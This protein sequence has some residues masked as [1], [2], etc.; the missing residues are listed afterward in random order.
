MGL[1]S[2]KRKENKMVFN[3][4]N[5]QNDITNKEEEQYVHTK[6]QKLQ[7]VENC[8]D[9]MIIGQR[10]L[11]ETKVE[12]NQVNHYLTDMHTIINLDNP[13]RDNLMHE[14]K[15]IINLK[16]DK[17]S[18]KNSANKMSEKKYE[19]ISNHEREM[20]QI[21]K[22]LKESEDD[23]QAIKVN[24]HNIEGEKSALKYERKICINRLNFYRKLL[25]I[26]LITTALILCAFTYGH[27]QGEYDYTIGYY[28]VIVTSMAS[29]AGIL[30]GNQIT[31]K[32]L[33]ISELKLNKAIGLLNRYKLRYVNTK[34][35]LD[36]LYVVYGVNNSYELSNLWRV[37]LTSKKEREAYFKMSDNLYKATENYMNIIN[38]LNLYDSSVWNYQVHAIIDLKEMDIIKNTLESR[39]ENLCKIIDY[40][41]DLVNRS[42]D[43]IKKLIED[44]NSITDDVLLIVER[45]EEEIQ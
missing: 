2:R 6:E 38:S 19:Y 36:Y 26:V 17:T 12:Y 13:I 43:R 39:R 24:L 44:D 23:C 32:N 20:P 42:K 33:K 9:Q 25:K 37:F 27:M 22:D 21:L 45:K 11:E 40:N 8:C 35:S 4:D 41:N 3:I 31:A 16:E 14:A 7:Y 28:I 15:R 5:E 29:I 18:Y 1:F 30:L 10:R 34:S